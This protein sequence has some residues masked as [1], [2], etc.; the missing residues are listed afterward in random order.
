MAGRRAIPT[1]IQEAKGAY[2]KNPG[3]RNDREPQA[4]PGWP[5][6]P[7]AVE[8]DDLARAK[9]F[10]TCRILADMKVLTTA[11]SNCIAQLCLAHSQQM[12]C[13]EV[14]KGG[15]TVFVGRLRPEA[16]DFH[17]YADRIIRC[18][19]ELGLTPSARTR[20]KVVKAEEKDDLLEWV[21]AGSN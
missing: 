15:N 7:E 20:V 3:R 10:E 12:R 1:A 11:D 21:S 18:S 6:I 16:K 5:E 19:V 14:I 13:W 2:A 17:V 8:G 4:E 9:W